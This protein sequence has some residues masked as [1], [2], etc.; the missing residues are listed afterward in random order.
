VCAARDD[1]I[2]ISLVFVK[3]AEMNTNYVITVLYLML[4]DF[5]TL[6]G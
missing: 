1:L 5:Y 3:Q 6:Y 4:E 2:F